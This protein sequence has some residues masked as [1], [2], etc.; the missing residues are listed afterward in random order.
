M[1]D[2]LPRIFSKHG[3]P[4]GDPH[5]YWSL[6]AKK[7]LRNKLNL[8]GRPERVSI[9]RMRDGTERLKVSGLKDRPLAEPIMARLIALG[10][11]DSKKSGNYL[12]LEHEIVATILEVID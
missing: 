7:K 1:E 11:D 3:P 12:I 10:A 4:I 8:I 5:G 6:S 2:S 9:Y